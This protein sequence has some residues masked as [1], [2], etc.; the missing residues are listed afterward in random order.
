MFKES[1]SNLSSKIIGVAKSAIGE[2]MPTAEHLIKGAVSNFAQQAIANISS[3]SPILGMLAENTIKNIQA[4]QEKNKN[5][6]AY[7]NSTKSDWLRDT[8]KTKE[9]DF[10]LS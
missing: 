10:F 8:T 7:V 4:D 1:V 2:N 3:R 6:N 5:I 9:T